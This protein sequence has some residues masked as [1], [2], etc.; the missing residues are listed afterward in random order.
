MDPPRP[1][2]LDLG[3]EGSHVVVTGGAGL[4]GRVV[5]DA[6]M[7]AGAHVSSLDISYPVDAA[8]KDH[9]QHGQHGEH[10][11]HVEIHCDISDE[12]SVRDAFQQATS[13][14]GPVEVC[15]ASAAL[16]LSVLQPASFADASFAQL[17]RVLDV[18]VA[19]TWLTAREWLRGLRLAKSEGTAVR[20]ANLV[21]V[22][23]E[24]GHFGERLNAEYS[25]AKSAVQVGLL[26]SLRAEAVR[27]WPGGIVRVNAIAPGAV[28]TE[29]W[30]AEVQENPEQLY[31][32]AQATTA[33]CQPIPREAVA[34]T[35]VML[36]SE[37]FSSHV[38]GQVIN[39]D[40]G[41]QGKV[42][43]TK[44]EIADAEA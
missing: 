11:E 5:V 13:T 19:G 32:E 3:L 18:N 9:G 4:I 21:I 28:A 40:G 15:I 26:M 29:R 12:L 2:S 27:E 39:V 25:L 7:A 35:I 44:Q 42:V 23:S 34:K 33:L 14:H 36:A 10:G 22:G 6:F 31:L 37:N 38:H 8:P 1:M 41:K 16:D 17:K 24:S 43:W 30:A 20:N